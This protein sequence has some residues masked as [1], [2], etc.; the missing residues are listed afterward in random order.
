MD[1]LQVVVA[2]L[3]L[4]AVDIWST[5]PAVLCGLLAAL[6]IERRQV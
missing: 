5:I 6:L 1:K 4:Q 2:V 3:V